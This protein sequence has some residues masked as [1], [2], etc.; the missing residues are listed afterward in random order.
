MTD[1][2]VLRAVEPADLGVFFVNQRDPE[3]VRMAAVPPRD[4]AAFD[5]HWRRILAD[6]TARVRTVV[7]DG[8]VAGNMLSWVDGERRL[9]GYWIGRDHWGRGI[10]SRALRAF[11][12]E[13][14]TRPLHALVSTANR[15]SVRVLEK[16]GFERIGAPVAG[17]D[18]IE[19]LTYELR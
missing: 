2:L 8:R 19:E 5:A 17:R 6:E 9:V 3:S 13:L 1:E 18:G 12:D 11:L 16:C 14:E 10:A 7:V 4:R 15:S